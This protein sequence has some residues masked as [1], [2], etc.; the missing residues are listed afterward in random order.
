MGVTLDGV[1]GLIGI[2]RRV[3]TDA[4]R[5]ALRGPGMGDIFFAAD[6]VAQAARLTGDLARNFPAAEGRYVFGPAVKIGWGT[7]TI[8][9]GVVAVLLEMPAPVRVVL[10]GTVSAAL[11]T[12]D[13]PVIDLH[14][15]VVGEVD[16]GQKRVAIDAS[17]R[18]STIAGFPIR[19]D[20]A[21]RLRWGDEPSFALAIGG[22]HSQFRA[23]PDFPALRRIEIP[24][25][26]GDDPRFDVQ[27]FLA[28]T[29]NTAQIG[30]QAEMYASAGPL[31][32]RGSLGFETLIVFSPFSLQ[33]DVWAGVKLRRGTTTLAGIHFDGHI[34]GPGPW[35]VDGK[36]TLSLWF[37]DLSVPVH[38]RFG[39]DQAVELPTRSIWPLLLAEVQR[40]ESW[41]TSLPPGLHAVTTAPP[42]GEAAAVRIDPG[43]SLTFRQKV[44]PLGRAITRF[45]Q[46]VPEG[47]SRFEVTEVRLGGRVEGSSPVT[48]WFAPAQFEALSDADKL[49]RPGFERMTSGLSVGGAEVRAPNG[50]TKTLTYETVIWG[51]AAR[52]TGAVYQPGHDAQVLATAVSATAQAPLRSHGSALY[53]PTTPPVFRLEEET[54]VI[55][56][57]A[58]LQAR[59]DVT[60]P[61]TRGEAELALRAH[62]TAAPHEGFALQVVPAHEAAA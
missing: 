35:R 60:G 48:D 18:D 28:L 19:G 51:G 2:H 12:R 20:L 11:P 7:P 53:G 10:L 21:F 14:I 29:S 32:I 56:S 39:A 15:D 23:P 33:V 6:P 46:R 22:F 26:S 49:S 4:L 54:Y 5:A 25:G 13:H 40:P 34:K 58:T 59:P 30:A 43:A 37:V 8:V 50:L 44:V 52:R 36:A 3:D 55:A 42:P 41:S 16:L 9:T 1:G 57:T 45:A 31:N 27:G 38:V 47:V 24:I 61:V 62:L 17:L